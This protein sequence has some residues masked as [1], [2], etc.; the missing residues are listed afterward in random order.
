MRKLVRDREEDLNKLTADTNG[1]QLAIEATIEEL[2]KVGEELGASEGAINARVAGLEAER[3]QKVADRGV[4]SK[5]VPVAI[6]R[7]YETIRQ[8]K[9]SALATTGDGTCRACNMALPP[10]LFHRLRREPLLE[11]CPSCFRLIYFSV[12]VQREDGAEGG[13]GGVA[14]RAVSEAR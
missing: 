9:G 2:K 8:K 11:Q 5:A 13:G 6:F 3:A 7:K 10:Q 4:A 12:A 1:M 14:S